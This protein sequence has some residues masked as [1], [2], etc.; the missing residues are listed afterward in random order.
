[1]KARTANEVRNFRDIPNV[2]PRIEDD[3]RLLGIK[4]P[5][6]L[7]GKDAYTLYKKL[8]RITGAHHDP[9]VLDTY[10]AVIDFMGGAPARPW[11]YYT[12]FRKKRYGQG[13]H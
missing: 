4:K 6:D 13:K 7:K 12:P 2:G 3:F 9:C 1:M 11:F 8:E 5:H 10:M